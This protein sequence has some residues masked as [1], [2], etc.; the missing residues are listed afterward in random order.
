MKPAVS[1]TKD[2]L[3]LRFIHRELSTSDLLNMFARSSDKFTKETAENALVNPPDLDEFRKE[4]DDAVRDIIR[5]GAGEEFKAFVNHYM[6]DSLIEDVQTM[7]GQFGE[8]ITRTA[9]VKDA[10]SPWVQ[11][12]LC[13][14][15]CLYLKVYGTECLKACKMC[16]KIFAHKGQYGV[17]CTDQCKAKGKLGSKAKEP[18]STKTGLFGP[19]S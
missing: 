5:E 12:L 7:P 10:E 13:Y 6:Q 3:F 19:I 16:G 4:I 2:P 18:P 9:R 17:Y 8:N 11:G 1:P 15:L 14:N